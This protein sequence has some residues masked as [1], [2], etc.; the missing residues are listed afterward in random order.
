MCLPL[1]LPSANIVTSWLFPEH[2]Q[3]HNLMATARPLSL[4]TYF[5]L[6]L[7]YIFAT[8][9]KKRNFPEITDYDMD[10]VIFLT[11]KH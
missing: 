9:T 2:S 8:V 5:R 6:K 11:G 3:F 4:C 7:K 1:F 10:Y